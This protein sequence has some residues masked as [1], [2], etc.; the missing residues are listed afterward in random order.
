MKR[1]GLVSTLLRQT[2]TSPPTYRPKS[3]PRRSLSTVY[4]PATPT[5][6]FYSQTATKSVA[7]ACPSCGSPL[8]LKEI[9]C[10]SCK[11]LSPLPE[12]VN[13]LSLFGFPTTSY[14]IDLR[15]LKSEYL[16]LMSKVHPDSVS[17]KSEVPPPKKSPPT[18]TRIK[19]E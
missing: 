17:Q 15:K 18:N 5:R 1:L 8:D 19:N 11:A 6:R 16:N 13:Y 9:S 12:N 4:S 7:K 14:D 10:K 3:L 2:T